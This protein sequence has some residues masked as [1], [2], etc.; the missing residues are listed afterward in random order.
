MANRRLTT[1]IPIWV[2][3]PGIIALVLVGI[4]I[5]T[6]LLGADRGSGGGHGSGDEMEMDGGDQRTSPATATLAPGGHG[7]GDQ[8]ETNGGGSPTPRLEATPT[9][10]SGDDTET[11]DGDH[12]SGNDGGHDSGE[13]TETDGGGHGSG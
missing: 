1:G 9:D 12:G 13:D 4:L 7:S 2:R 10:G 8:T 6:M 11:D 5:S 3:V